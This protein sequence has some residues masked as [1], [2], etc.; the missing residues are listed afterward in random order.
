MANSKFWRNLAKAFRALQV[1]S[2][3]CAEWHY[4]VGKGPKEWTL[5]EASPM[6]RIRFEAVARRG[7]AALSGAGGSDWLVVWLEALRL[8]SG[9]SGF[10]AERSGTEQNTDG[11]G[12]A[13]HRSGIIW[14]VCEASANYCDELEGRARE[15]EL[16]AKL[17]T[18]EDHAKAAKT[19]HHDGESVGRQIDRLRKECALTEEELAEKMKITTRSVQRHIS[20]TC[21]PLSRSV[22]GYSRL[23]SKLLGRQIV[24]KNMS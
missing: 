23:F 7:A 16:R 14:R 3:M 22:T 24:I 11:T 17:K 20:D 10:I 21:P 18:Q 8:A 6:A 9:T 4:I 1:N 5:A 12:V 2:R 19:V 15:A 13:H